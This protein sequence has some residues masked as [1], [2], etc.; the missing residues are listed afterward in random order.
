MR[1]ERGECGV[2]KSVAEF[3]KQIEAYRRPLYSYCYRLLHNP[4]HAEDLTQEVFIKAYR[5]INNLKDPAA[6]KNWLYRI[7]HNC[8][9]DALRRQRIKTAPL[10]G[11]SEET[12]IPE[13]PDEGPSPLEKL[14][15]LENTELVREALSAIKPKYGSILVL[16]EIVGLSYNEIAETLEMSLT[17]V[18]THI[19]RARLEVRDYIL[20]KGGEAL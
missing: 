11:E 19:R 13:L 8:A 17:N 16:R 18:K 20:R 9:V 4:E 3:E 12:Y 15:A 5:A 7:A 1:N 10:S 14:V 2:F 6:F